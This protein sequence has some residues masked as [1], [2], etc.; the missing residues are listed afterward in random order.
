[1]LYHYVPYEEHLCRQ[2]RS[3][4]AVDLQWESLDLFDPRIALKFK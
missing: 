4:F 1:M 2:K 3:W